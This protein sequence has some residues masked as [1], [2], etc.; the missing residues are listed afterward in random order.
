MYSNF[1]AA[2]FPAFL[3]YMS[4]YCGFDTRTTII[5]FFIKLDK[6]R[7]ANGD[8]MLRPVRAGNNPDQKIELSWWYFEDDCR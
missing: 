8:S 2:G 5:T 1:R 7:I 6:F 3:S 4:I